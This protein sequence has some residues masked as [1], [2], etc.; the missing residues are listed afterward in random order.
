MPFAQHSESEPVG[1]DS[2]FAALEVRWVPPYSHLSP[3]TTRASLER[4]WVFGLG[5]RSAF[6]SGLMGQ[7]IVHS[8]EGLVKSQ[9]HGSFRNAHC[10]RKER[11]RRNAL[12]VLTFDL[13]GVIGTGFWSRESSNLSQMLLIEML[14]DGLLGLLRE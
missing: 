8:R 4:C 5:L 12:Q 13:R 14:L 10:R 7:M 6:R 11:L 1:Q 2:H 9:I 3:P